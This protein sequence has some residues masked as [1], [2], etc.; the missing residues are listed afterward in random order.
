MHNASNTSS[1]CSCPYSREESLRRADLRST[2]ST[3]G[4]F[5]VSS[6]PSASMHTP[7]EDSLSDTHSNYLSIDMT[8]E[9]VKDKPAHISRVLA[10]KTSINKMKNQHEATHELLQDLIDRLGPMQA[11]NMHSPIQRPPSTT[12]SSA[13]QRN[14]SLKPALPLDFSGDRNAG[15]VFLISCQ[16]YIQLC[17]EPFDN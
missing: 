11:L 13:G 2:M 9:M 7:F 1:D 14:I 10:L 5:R 4:R 12:T 8:H 3:I 15:K 17:P 6:T 16:T